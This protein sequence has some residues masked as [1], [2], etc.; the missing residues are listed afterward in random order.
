MWAGFF[1]L[2]SNTPSAIWAEQ[3]FIPEIVF[4]SLVRISALKFSGLRAHFFQRGRRTNSQIPARQPRDQ[5]RRKDTFA[6]DEGQE[7]ISDQSRHESCHVT[8]L[9]W[10]MKSFNLSCHLYLDA[11]L[12]SEVPLYMDIKWCG[13][14]GLKQKVPFYVCLHVG[15]FC[16][17]WFPQRRIWSSDIVEGWCQRQ[18]FK[19]QS[20]W[21]RTQKIVVILAQHMCFSKFPEGD[22]LLMRVLIVRKAALI[23]WQWCFYVWLRQFCY[24]LAATRRRESGHFWSV[25]VRA[26]GTSCILIR[27]RLVQEGF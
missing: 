12:Y 27:M 6:G 9:G 11:R 10:Q 13:W 16:D 2:L 5:I 7:G 14:P 19:F 15:S 18:R 22:L 17:S 4:F 8:F 24:I 25:L 23:T 20:L 1:S 3:M 26:L 21:V